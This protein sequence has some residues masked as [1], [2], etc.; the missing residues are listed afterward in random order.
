MP[1]N[2]VGTAEIVTHVAFQ[3]TAVKKEQVLGHELT[4]V[5][6]LK[7]LDIAPVKFTIYEGQVIG[8]GYTAIEYPLFLKELLDRDQLFYVLGFLKCLFLVG[9]QVNE[10]HLHAG[11]VPVNPMNIPDERPVFLEVGQGIVG[12]V[13]LGGL[14][15]EEHTQDGRQCQDRS[16]ETAVGKTEHPN[17]HPRQTHNP[18]L[19]TKEPCPAGS[20]DG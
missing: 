12:Y 11:Q 16:W 2:N 17:E 1:N 3:V 6:Y 8:Q 7:I 20:H 19:I 18:L 10:E 9:L 5:G 4:P 13:K 15:N 14:V